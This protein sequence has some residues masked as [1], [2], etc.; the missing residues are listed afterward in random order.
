M[1]LR[2]PRV[3][4]RYNAG[5]VQVIVVFRNVDSLLRLYIGCGKI[6]YQD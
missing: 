2:R 3:Y 5:L 4:R 6:I 1:D